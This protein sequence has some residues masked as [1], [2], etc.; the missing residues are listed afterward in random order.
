MSLFDD[1]SQFL[2]ERLDEF[3]EKNPHLEFQALEEQLRE[4][5][6]DTSKLILQL[7]QQEKNLQDQILAL[8]EEIKIWHRR[9]SKAQAANKKDSSLGSISRGFQILDRKNVGNSLLKLAYNLPVENEVVRRGGCHMS[10]LALDTKGSQ[11]GFDGHWQ[12]HGQLLLVGPPFRD[13][14]QPCSV[15]FPHQ[16]SQRIR[17][18]IGLDFH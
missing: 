6:R 17:H 5:E 10:D 8:A 1:L 4:Q 2:E 9:V 14:F 7:Q 18:R 16:S 12:S 15:Q 3:L 11:R 13:H